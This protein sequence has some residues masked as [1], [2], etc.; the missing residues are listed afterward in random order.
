MYKA[1]LR[2][3]T[4]KQCMDYFEEI[5]AEAELRSIGQCV[6]AKFVEMNKRTFAPGRG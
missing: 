3:E 4:M 6:P 1:I 5:C 2:L